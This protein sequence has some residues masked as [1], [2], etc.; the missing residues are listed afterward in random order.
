VLEHLIEPAAVLA[1]FRSYLRPGGRVLVS[2]PNVAHARVRLDLARG[3]F[4]YRDY[5]VLDRTHLHFYTFSSAQEL[6]RTAGYDVVRTVGGSNRLGPLVCVP[7][8]RTLLSLQVL[9]TA[10]RK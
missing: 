7:G 10:E 2:V 3:R 5:G 9:V 1:H 6:M 8:L 4:D